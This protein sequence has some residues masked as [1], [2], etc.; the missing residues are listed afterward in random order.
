[1]KRVAAIA[2]MLLLT[3]SLRA[4]WRNLKPGMSPY[5]AWKC[6]G[7]PLMQYGARGTE[8]W[9]F[10]AGGYVQFEN[11]QVTCWSEP[12]PEK[13]RASLPTSEP[14]LE[15]KADES[16][17]ASREQHSVTPNPAAEMDTSSANSPS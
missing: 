17:T 4:E 7:M 6:T 9:T 5:A 15:I 13:P 16:A 14:R 3:A 8:M 12:K 11:G 10:D 2:L 1:M